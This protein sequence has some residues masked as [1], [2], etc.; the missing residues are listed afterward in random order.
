[1]NNR[2]RELR[3]AVR[4]YAFRLATAG[5]NGK[6]VWQFKLAQAELRLHRL[7]LKR[8]RQANVSG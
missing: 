6:P 8:G 4:E 2:E 7:T 5:P 3:D 1:M